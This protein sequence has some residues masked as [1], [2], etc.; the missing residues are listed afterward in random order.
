MNLIIP[1]DIM[2]DIPMGMVT[3]IIPLRQVVIIGGLAT[4]DI[5][6]KIW[7]GKFNVPGL[8]KVRTTE[9]KMVT[10]AIFGLFLDYLFLRHSFNYSLLFRLQPRFP[11]SFKSCSHNLYV[12]SM[13]HAPLGGSRKSINYPPKVPASHASI[14]P[15]RLAN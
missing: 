3:G 12:R 10:K 14:G 5:I 2:V 15:P 6:D 13:S 11:S 9:P 7:A 1:V 8:E 4:L